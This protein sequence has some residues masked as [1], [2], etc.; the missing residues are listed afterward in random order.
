M[1]AGI[2]DH[3]SGTRDIRKLSGLIKLMPYTATLAMV[4]SASMAGVPLL[5]GFLSKEMFFAET[6]FI[7]STAWVEAALPVIA[8]VAGTFSVA[9]S[10]RFTVDVFFGPKA[11]NL[12]HT[13]H[14]PPRWM[15]VPVELLVLACLIVGIFPAQSVG[16]LLAAAAQPVVGGTLPEYSLAIWHGLNAPMIM[17][18]IAMGAGI[19]LYL[20]LR[21]PIKRER[22]VGPPLI[23]R[24]NGK[25]LFER[26][27]IR[28]LRIARTLESLLTTRRLQAQ[29]FLMVTVALIAGFG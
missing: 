26:V 14:E 3:E 16:P 12:P 25:Q 9:Y 8:T 7:T 24:L 20:L 13:P 27:L 11:N 5:N 1:A 10:L 2:I 15:R 28:K 29:L 21:K 17:S 6:V 19:L 23:W 18:L 22:F 4:A